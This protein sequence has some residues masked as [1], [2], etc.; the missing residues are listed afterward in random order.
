VTSNPS[1]ASEF[2]T[3]STLLRGLGN[4]QDPE[5]FE[6]SWR[7]FHRKYAVIV[8]HW[9]ESNWGLGPADADDIAA[10]VMV[11]VLRTIK[12]F[13]YRRTGSFR[14]WMYTVTRRAVI[15]YWNSERHAR[16]THSA[17]ALNSLQA[18]EDLLQ[19][20]NEEFDMELLAEARRRVEREA[21][22]R[23]WTIFVEL[24]EQGRSPVELAEAYQ[25][26]RNHVDNIKLRVLNALRQEI[27][28]LEAAGMDS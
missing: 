20:L 5:Q 12:R 17:D 28:L 21:G 1:G 13:Q 6:A 16:H 2:R 27:R 26:T 25:L 24:T 22:P 11:K 7:R 4:V 23:D 8:A 19:R 10:D 18:R 14:A 9:C 15:D 3:S